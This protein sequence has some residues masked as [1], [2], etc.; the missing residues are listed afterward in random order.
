M[1]KG[2]W[3][4]STVLICLGWAGAVPHALGDLTVNEFTVSEQPGCW[5]VSGTVT[6]A[7]PWEVL[8]ELTGVLG[9][10]CLGL[11]GNG[12]FSIDLPWDVNTTGEVAA[13]AINWTGSVSPVD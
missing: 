6:G 8:V 11:D 13:R 4:V 10:H 7:D 12:S 2:A 9:Y 3:A 1:R 5:R